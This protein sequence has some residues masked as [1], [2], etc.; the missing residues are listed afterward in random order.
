MDTVVAR[1][2]LIVLLTLTA[3]VFI[4][5]CAGFAA[6]IMLAISGH[7]LHWHLFWLVGGSIGLVFGLVIAG[8]NKGE[9]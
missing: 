7:E 9:Q 6:A 3:S 5:G 1:K 8:K 4:G 2:A